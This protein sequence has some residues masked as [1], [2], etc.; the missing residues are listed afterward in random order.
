[1][2]VFLDTRSW[3][4]VSLGS[5]AAFSEFWEN[6]S[7]WYLAIRNLDAISAV[8]QEV[9]CVT[10]LRDLYR[11][12]AYG[13]EGLH[14]RWQ[15]HEVD[16]CDRMCSAARAF[17]GL[18]ICDD[19]LLAEELVAAAVQLLQNFSVSNSNSKHSAKLLVEAA[20]A[21]QEVLGDDAI[22]EIYGAYEMA[23]AL[24]ASL[25]QVDSELVQPGIAV[26]LSTGL[27]ISE[28]K[29]DLVKREC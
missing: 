18:Q 4:H 6:S 27:E 20:T 12:V 2:I 8:N 21:A 16:P 11:R 14:A 26:L 1:M 5:R 10:D 17:H 29:K 7:L 9:M 23:E 15:L 3:L 24:C 19:P 25:R 28:P 13:I 22:T